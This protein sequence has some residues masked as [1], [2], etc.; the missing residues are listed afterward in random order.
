MFIW[1]AFKGLSLLMRAGLIV[2]VIAAGWGAW[3]VKKWSL[4]KEG[5]IAALEKVAKA[6][7]AESDRRM[8][9]IDLAR[10][11]A[12]RLAIDLAAADARNTTLLEEV[13]RASAVNDARACLD[14]DAARRLSNIG[15]GGG[16]KARPRAPLPPRRPAL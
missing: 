5:Q 9:A 8:V 4:R 12:D 6:T 16:R 2:G 1:A 3:E 14:V 15:P 11:E 7:K 10:A 13:A